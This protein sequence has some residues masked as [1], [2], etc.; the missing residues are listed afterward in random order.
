MFLSSRDGAKEF[1]ASKDTVC[2]WLHELEHYGFIVT[3]QGAH[4]GMHGTGKAALYRLT[5]CCYA[6]KPPTYDF[7][8]W[9]G[10]LFEDKKQNPGLRIRP[11]RPKKPAIREITKMALNGNKRPTEPSIRNE[12]EWPKI[13][14]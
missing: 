7:Q 8:N 2:R 11:P 1:G 9:D 10:V 14:P 3:V 4:L 12:E 5:D 13:R 6:G